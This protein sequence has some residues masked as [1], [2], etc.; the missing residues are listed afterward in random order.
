MFSL[1]AY[2]ENDEPFIIKFTDVDGEVNGKWKPLLVE[3][4]LR[5]FDVEDDSVNEFVLERDE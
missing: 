1:W 4:D 2:N 3:K 5:G